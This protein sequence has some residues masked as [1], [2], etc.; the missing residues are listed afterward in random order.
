MVFT[1]LSRLLYNSKILCKFA[2]YFIKAQAKDEET[3]FFQIDGQESVERHLYPSR[4]Q[5][6]PFIL[7]DKRW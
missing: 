7:E 3:K 5:E 6:E 1:F 2:T 4:P